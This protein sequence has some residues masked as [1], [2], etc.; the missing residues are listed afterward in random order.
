MVPL[1]ELL[2]EAIASAYGGEMHMRLPIAFLRTPL[3]A[4]MGP[5]G[6]KCS[7]QGSH[8]LGSYD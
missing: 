4:V 5:A 6:S 7:E 1:D 8:S 2:T 3:L